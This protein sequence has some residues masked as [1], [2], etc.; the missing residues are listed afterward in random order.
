MA[1]NAGAAAQAAN[2]VIQDY[3]DRGPDSAYCQFLEIADEGPGGWNPAYGFA[4]NLLCDPPPPPAPPGTDFF[5]AGGVPCR[6]YRVTYAAG[7]PGGPF[8]NTELDRRGPIGMIVE[9]YVASGGAPG[10]NYILTSGNGVGCERIVDTMSG[11]DNVNISPPFAKIVSIVPLE[12]TP[13]TE[14][15]LYRPPLD[16]PP[17]GDFEV[18]INIPF[19]VDGF[20]VEAPI[21]FGPVVNTPFGPLIQFTFSPTANFNPEI[22]IDL[23]LNPQFGLELNLEFV[24]PLT[25]PPSSPVPVPGAEPIPL[26]DVRPPVGGDC[27]EFDYER[28]ENFI[29]AN[30]CCDPITSVVSVGSFTF[31]GLNDV[32]EFSVPDNTVAVFLGIVPS[33][34]ARAYKLAGPDS[35]YGHGNATLTSRGNALGFERLYVN[36]HVMFFPESADT[37]GVRVSC[38]RGTIVSVN[39]GVY[40]PVAEM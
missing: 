39:A 36:N 6:L 23:G 40:V 31:E 26:P 5:D 12:G 10:R 14:I 15:P 34:N 13:E 19:N 16:R 22:D 25:G 7:P 30:R 27:E 37:K 4:R 38:V 35:E 1:G 2:I 29:I 21:N 17:E 33:N 20:E 32:A 28:I 11:S 9:N 24:V 3:L 8:I 18:T